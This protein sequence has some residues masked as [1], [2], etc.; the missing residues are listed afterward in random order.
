MTDQ[1]RLC[2]NDLEYTTEQ[3]AYAIALLL[4]EWLTDFT[5]IR[6]SRKGTGYDY[7]LGYADEN[8]GDNYLRGMARLEVS[9]IRSGNSSLIRTRVKLKQ[10]QVRPT[11]GV[12]PAYIVVIEFSHPLAQVVRK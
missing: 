3:G 8:Q 4:T 1:M 2:W 10:A 7:L 11:D 5:V 6:R 9:G 12:L